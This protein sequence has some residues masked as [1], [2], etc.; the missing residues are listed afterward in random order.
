M[1]CYFEVAGWG[2]L[3]IEIVVFVVLWFLVV[4]LFC[5]VKLCVSSNLWITVES[6][7]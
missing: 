5:S 1:C 6:A 4:V 2:P 3:V 7:L